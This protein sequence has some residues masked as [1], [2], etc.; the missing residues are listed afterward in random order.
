M[1]CKKCCWSA[2]NKGC[3]MFRYIRR[4]CSRYECCVPR[5]RPRYSVRRSRFSI[6]AAPAGDGLISQAERSPASCPA[7][8]L[9]RIPFPGWRGGCPSA[10]R[11]PTSLAQSAAHK[12]SRLGSFRIPVCRPACGASWTLCRLYFAD[13]L[14][15]KKTAVDCFAFICY[16]H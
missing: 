7:M 4:N 5:D 16:D 9:R 10:A 13:F 12:C 6:S 2:S 11:H 1:Y 3:F 15:G 8:R 14:F